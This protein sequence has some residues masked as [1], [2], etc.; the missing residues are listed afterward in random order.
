[1]KTICV[2]QHVEAEYL[3]LIED[4]LESRNVRFRYFRP[5]TA[6][7]TVPA[8]SSE[9]DG[10]IL[11][12]LG[13]LGVV[14]GPL[15]PSLAPELRLTRDFVDR[16]LPVI[17]I[18]I[19]AV[20]LAIAAGGGAEEAPLRFEVGQA[21]RTRDDALAGGLPDRFPLAWFLRDRAVLPA[22][23]EI[24]ATGDD[25]EPLVFAVRDNAI[26]FI[27]HPGIKSGMVEDIVMEFEDTPDS[28]GE[29]LER[30]RAVQPAIAEALSTIMVGLVNT[31]GWMTNADN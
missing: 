8:D 1:M 2:L 15:I 19:G 20:I 5:F 26:G 28:V 12:G 22:G 29:E 13:P 10:L 24:L 7:G 30:L 31:T 4:H 14:S 16:G 11:L 21:T 25:G 3:G 17:G 27:G 18:G 23:S 6:G 9:F